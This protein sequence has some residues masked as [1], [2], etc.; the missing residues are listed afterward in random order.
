MLFKR[1]S[2]QGKGESEEGECRL[3]VA[4]KEEGSLLP[5]LLLNSF[6]TW[7]RQSTSP[8]FKVIFHSRL[9]SL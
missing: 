5:F 2:G 9:L 8:G 4:M 7:E 3:A 6:M 1:G